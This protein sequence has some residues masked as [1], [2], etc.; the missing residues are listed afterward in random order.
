MRSQRYNWLNQLTPNISLVSSDLFHDY[1]PCQQGLSPYNST[2]FL[3]P[4]LTNNSWAGIRLENSGLNTWDQGSD[5][6][7]FL[8]SYFWSQKVDVLRIGSS[9]INLMTSYDM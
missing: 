4:S 3:I 2:A 6:I 5:G 7:A 8:P 9:G 1:K